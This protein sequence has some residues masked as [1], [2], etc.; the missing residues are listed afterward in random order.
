MGYNLINNKSRKS[1]ISSK[2]G[3]YGKFIVILVCLCIVC[4]LFVMIIKFINKPAESKIEQFNNP[5]YQVIKTIWDNGSGFYSV[6]QFKLNHY[7]YAKKYNLDFVMSYNNWPYTFEHGWTDY[8]EDVKLESTNKSGDKKVR[9]IGGCCTI[10]E[11]FPIRDY[12]AIL[13]QFYKYNKKI[14]DLIEKKK[15]ELGLVN[16][17]YGA[18]Y[19]RRGDK[20]VDENKYNNASKFI[21]ILLANYSKCN[22]IFVQTDD[23]NSYLEAK[24]YVHKNLHRNDINLITLCP[25]NVFGAIA[26]A[27]YINKMSSNDVTNENKEYINKIKQNLS[28]SI[29]EMNP[30][31]RFDHTIEL[32]ISVDIC[33]H[34]KVTVCDFDSNVSR[35]IKLA[36]DDF[37]SVFDINGDDKIINLDSETCMG[38]PVNSEHQKIK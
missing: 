12:I 7:L 10:L 13:P 36:H 23:Y 3:K 27:G 22:I 30:Q 26:H 17:Q 2:P 20:L 6:L 21:D 24:E 18:I 32:L 25:E 34:S 15:Q 33:C 31:E 14:K 9:D 19:I 11:H 29:S 5:D 35:F 38:F 28:K 1:I 37:Y 4:I 16:G 8:F